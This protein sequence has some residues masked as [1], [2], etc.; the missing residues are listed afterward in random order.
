MV[1]PSDVLETSWREQVV[2]LPR[3]PFAA[4]VYWEVTQDAF[5]EERPLI[6]R[7]LMLPSDES[8]TFE[9][10]VFDFPVES[11]R[12]GRF[13]EFV[14]EDIRHVAEIGHR[15]EDG[16]FRCLVRS[17]VVRSPRT[18]A[19]TDPAH[20]VAVQVTENGLQVRDVEHRVPEGTLFAARRGGS[21]VGSLSRPRHKR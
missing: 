2:L 17:E 8:A 1:S 15:G 5:G 13:V 9:R 21:S 4:Y 11:V 18:F 20:F 7:L 12:D 16:E 6:G 10:E 3:D 14:G 19:G